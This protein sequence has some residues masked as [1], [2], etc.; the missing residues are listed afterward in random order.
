LQIASVFVGGWTLEALE[1]IS[2][3][4][5]TLELLEQ[6]VNKSLVVTE[7]R[8]GEMRY[9]MLETIRQYAREKL[10]E[11]RQA[12][13]ARDSHFI[14]FDELSEKFWNIFMSKNTL[15]WRDRADDE[16][17]NF[18]A[19]LEWGLDHDVERAIHLAAN[20]CL[21]CGWMGSGLTGGLELN[22]TAIERFKD[23]PAVEGNPKAQ[24]Q[25]LLAKALFAQGVVGMGSGNMPL[26]LQDLQEAIA[27]A[28]AA[29]DKRM[30]GY[31]L[32]MFFTAA[33][34]IKTP[35]A[36]EAAEEGY[37]IF[38]DEVNDTW[39]L[40]MGYQNMARLAS[41]RGD[42]V[43]KNLYLAK[44]KELVQKAPVSFQAGLFHLGTGMNEKSLGNYEAAKSHFEDG[45]EI[46]KQI[47][48][49]NFEL[50][51]SSELGHVAR[52]TGNMAEAIR[53]Y[54]DTLGGWQN[55][56]NRGAIANQLECFAFI[57]IIQQEPQRAAKL[58]GAAEALREMVQSPMTEYE[59]LEYDQS[60]ATLQSMLPAAEFEALWADGRSMNT[61]QAI[62]LALG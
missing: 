48:N 33:Q 37:R 42:H 22:K 54:R 30:L 16:V 49:K 41:N 40:S 44:F 35:G 38:R 46:F 43:K 50:V 29:D 39:G 47:R 27:N 5:N 57:A 18:R 51:M 20:F 9:F 4:P 32:E 62:Q 12:S 14:Y 24:R 7:E 28:R 11:A 1:A 55:L 13:T 2:E 10:F 36:D 3:D 8:P 53:I 59:R 31:S 58:L 21:V 61:E 34:F 6:L 26:V 25:R 45:L 23:L 60:V 56:G 19:A 15:F 52:H 17:E